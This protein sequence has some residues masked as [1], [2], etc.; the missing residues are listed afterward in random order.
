MSEINNLDRLSS[1]IASLN[2]GAGIG[3]FP[4]SVRISEELVSDVEVLMDV[5]LENGA[6][7]F[8]TEGG[9]VTITTEPAD[10]SKWRMAARS[11]EV[12]V[13]RGTGYSILWLAGIKT[14]PPSSGPTSRSCQ[15]SAQQQG[16]LRELLGRRHKGSCCAYSCTCRCAGGT[17]S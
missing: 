16:S 8:E 4:F 17:P 15:A 9:V 11:I 1:F 5:A 7:D 13:G 14:N 12:C 6:E 3:F 2:E 10:T